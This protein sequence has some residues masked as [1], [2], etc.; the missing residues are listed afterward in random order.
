MD[1]LCVYHN[2]NNDDKERKE[3][4]KETKNNDKKMN[5][6]HVI[7]HGSALDFAWSIPTTAT[8]TPYLPSNTNQTTEDNE[9][10]RRSHCVVPIGPRH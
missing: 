8:T 5:K 9:R 3:K 4:Q 6:F 2:N 10:Y 7:T 1:I